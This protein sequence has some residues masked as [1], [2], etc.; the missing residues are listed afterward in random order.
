MALGHVVSLPQYCPVVTGDGEEV[1]AFITAL[2]R[3]V[4]NPSSH[5]NRPTLISRQPRKSYAPLYMSDLA[6]PQRLCP[7]S[8]AN[9][10]TEEYLEARFLP[11]LANTTS[12]DSGP[13]K[14]QKV[15]I[16][17]SKLER[18]LATANPSRQNHPK[19]SAAT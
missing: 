3:Q 6:S 5:N 16:N 10:E 4:D 19:L 7:S 12:K 11:V 2:I 1:H 18:S 8:Q 13:L 14:F 15:G 9:V 17:K